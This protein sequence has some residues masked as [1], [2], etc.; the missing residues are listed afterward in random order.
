MKKSILLF[1]LSILFSN[2]TIHA[3]QIN[4]PQNYTWIGH[5]DRIQSLD[6][7]INSS[8]SLA[9]NPVDY[10]NGL[11]QATLK[12]QLKLSNAIDSLKTD[13]LINRLALHFFNDLAYGNH[14]PSLQNDGIEFKQRTINVTALLNSYLR[15]KG[16]PQLVHYFTNSSSALVSILKTLKQYRDS[17]KINFSRIKQLAK[18]ANDYRWLRAL[19]ENQRVVLVNLPSAQLKVFEQDKV[20]LSMKLIVGKGSTQTNTF[21][22]F[23][24]QVTV[25]PYWNVPHSI[26]VK[27]MLPKLK[28][29]NEYL[30]RNHLQVLSEKRKILNASSINWNNYDENNFPYFI[31]QS[32]G[33][34]NSLGVL[35][36]EFDSPYGVYLHDTPEKSLFNATSRFYSHGCMRME[37][38]IEMARLLMDKNR[39]ALDTIDLEKCY[40]NPNP[41][42]ISIPVPAP[43]IV[44]YSLVDFDNQG[45]I[46][47]YKDVYHRF[48]Y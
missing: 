40:D 1:L 3:Q 7:I 41:I 32:T 27:E 38:P 10:N 45:A 46:R 20:L 16:L 15:T 22:T 18:A 13:S 37:K 48:T 31:R 28:K 12:K 43:L 25:N 39:L 34:D 19:S 47:F 44:W 30:S 14:E 6:S 42:K 36:L 23:I 26:A 9:L 2:E 35:K 33:C 17:T 21:S 24:K 4:L 5:L 8:A 29:D 11:L